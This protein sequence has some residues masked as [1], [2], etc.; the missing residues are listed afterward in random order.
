MK[1]IIVGC[2]RIGSGLALALDKDGH[3]VTVIDSN[4]DAFKVL[5]TTFRGHTV[6]G[7]GFDQ[8]VLTH[9]GITRT[10]AIAAF[11]SNDEANTVIARLAR[12]IYR[13]PKVIAGLKDGR[14]AAL[15]RAMGVQ[16]ISATQWSIAR[17]VDMLSHSFLESVLEIGGG[18][19]EVYVV[20]VPPALEGHP[21][22]E[23]SLPGETLVI[24]ITRDSRTFIPVSGTI[25]RS[26]D[27]LHIAVDHSAMEHFTRILGIVRQN[28]EKK[29]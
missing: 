15:Y 29:L 17:A 4:D 25:L 11:T 6:T 1:I 28:K 10:D 19:V 9:A 18:E 16:T 8:E 13:V 14:K 5:G 3:T 22:R 24:S 23:L 26:G 2:G 21:A 12:D 7:I 27:E 20:E